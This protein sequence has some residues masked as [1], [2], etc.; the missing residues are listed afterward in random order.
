MTVNYTLPHSPQPSLI[1]SHLL[2]PTTPAHSP[3]PSLSSTSSSMPHYTI[4]RHEYRKQQ[5]TPTSLSSTPP[6]KTL[7][8]KPASSALND[9]ERAPSLSRTPDTTLQSPFRAPHYSYSSQHLPAYQPLSQSTPFQQQ[10]EVQER[11]PR[12]H[13]AE[14]LSLAGRDGHYQSTGQAD[15]FCRAFNSLSPQKVR[16]WK[17]I[18]RLP[19]PTEVQPSA[20]HHV[21][22]P[23]FVH[24]SSSLASVMP[25]PPRSSP[26]QTCSSTGNRIESGEQATRP[27]FSLSR[28]PKPPPLFDLSCSPPSDGNVAPRVDLTFIT[29]APA[30]TPATPA[31]L[32]VVHYRGTLLDVVNSH[33]SLL[34]RDIEDSPDHLLPRSSVEPFFQPEVSVTLWFH[35]GYGAINNSSRWLPNVP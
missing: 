17:P 25:A 14:P 21:F 15:H 27:T 18:K 8:R 9:L 5:N 6:G 20:N 33:D 12:S 30:I 16:N 10:P 3:H 35:Y 2:N 13:S 4:S 22:R 7:R 1:H 29:T 28:F 11:P 32:D 23:S 31:T 19:N 34:L 24:H 26:D